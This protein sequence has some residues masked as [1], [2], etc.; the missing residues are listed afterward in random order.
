[1]RT[2]EKQILEA[3]INQFSKF[4]FK[5]TSIDDIAKAAGVGKGT[6]YNYFSSKEELFL[7]V[8]NQH[9][10]RLESDFNGR[11]NQY[12]GTEDPLII[13]FVLWFREIKSVKQRYGL[14]MENFLE[15]HELFQRQ[16]N[17]KVEAKKQ[18]VI[19]LLKQGVKAGRYQPADHRQQADV[20]MSLSMQ[21]T[22]KW[23]KMEDVA[24]EKDIRSII[25]LFLT[26][27]LN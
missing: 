8:A 7:R 22:P 18:D 23:L 1:M 4:G 12:Q 17:D 2:K 16:N 5:K 21:Y 19:D 14:T 25:G 27:I 6:V 20:L 24:M 13:F 11:L 26:G 3:G 15:L 10:E 9:V